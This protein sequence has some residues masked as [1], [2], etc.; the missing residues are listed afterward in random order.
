MH[1]Q[2]GQID[3]LVLGL[4][5]SL[6]EITVIKRVCRQKLPPTLNQKPPYSQLPDCCQ[7]EPYV[8]PIYAKSRGIVNA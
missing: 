3:E 7:Q 5:A 4:I 1:I 8:F 2:Y 6:Q